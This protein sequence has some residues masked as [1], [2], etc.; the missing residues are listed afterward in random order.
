LQPKSTARLDKD[1]EKGRK[2]TVATG[3]DFKRGDLIIQKKRCVTHRFSKPW[4]KRTAA[5]TKIA[6]GGPDDLD[7]RRE[8]GEVGWI[9]GGSS[10]QV[11]WLVG[12]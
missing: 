10:K 5:W 8:G 1:A 11:E 7:R 4:H 3:L 2:K 6:P 12:A 9:R